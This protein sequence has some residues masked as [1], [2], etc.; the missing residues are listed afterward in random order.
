MSSAQILAAKKQEILESWFQAT[1]D[2]Y[3]AETA[4]FI[5]SQKDPF[6]NP[7]GQATYRSLEALVEAL[8]AGHGREVMTTALDPI[9]RIRAVQTFTPSMATS[10]V[11]SLKQIIRQHLPG[12][13][14]DADVD[15]NALDRQIDE[16]AMAAFD[17]YVACREK[18]Y[19]LKATE[20]RKQFFGSLKRAG[21]IDETAADGPGF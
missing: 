14:R 13:G 19:E 5:K 7:V 11:F 8:T 3:P 18:I 21:L 16:M 10:F 2:S 15:M 1:V 17:I 12:D 9:L 6:A 4:R 20:S